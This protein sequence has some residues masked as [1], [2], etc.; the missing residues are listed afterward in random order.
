MQQWLETE[1]AKRPIRERL[2]PA[3]LL[4]GAVARALQSHPDLN[5]FWR[6]DQ[7]VRMKEIHINF[8]IATRQGGL[9]TPA[10]HDVA[11]KT[12]G[13]IM[14]ALHDLIPRAK[15]GRLRSSQLTDGTITVTSLGSMTARLASI[16]GMDT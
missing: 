9:I 1:N 3:A 8:A 7:L 4:L 16:T 11:G 2:L 6:D 15:E 5:G 12:I 14:A 13:E 10:I